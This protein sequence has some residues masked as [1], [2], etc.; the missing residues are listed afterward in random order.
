[1]QYLYNRKN[2]THNSMMDFEKTTFTCLCFELIK[3][4]TFKLV[5]SLKLFDSSVVCC[6]VPL[7]KHCISIR[8]PISDKTSA[9]TLKPRSTM[10]F[11]NHLV[12]DTC[13]VGFGAGQIW[14][15]DEHSIS[16][17]RDNHHRFYKLSVLMYVG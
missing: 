4:T 8:M 13:V 9:L 15:Q 16:I 3:I 7:R 14:N 2:N 5:I 17:C 12:E 1:M 11:L 6:T 10:Y